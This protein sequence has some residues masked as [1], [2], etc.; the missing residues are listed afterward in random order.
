MST[1]AP[2]ATGL[3]DVCIDISCDSGNSTLEIYYSNFIASQSNA[4]KYLQYRKIQYWPPSHNLTWLVCVCAEC[5]LNYGT[6]P[7]SVTVV[8]YNAR[9]RTRSHSCASGVECSPAALDQNLQLISLWVYFNLTRDGPVNAVTNYVFFYTARIS[10]YHFHAT[11]HCTACTAII[12][13]NIF[14][15]TAH[16]VNYYRLGATESGT[17]FDPVR[18]SVVEQ[19]RMTE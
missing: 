14:C 16:R 18:Q 7:P 2:Y 5:S 6:P 4:Q 11:R 19:D 10:I 8:L 3:Q 9:H 1:L 13:D 12:I 17:G 15:K